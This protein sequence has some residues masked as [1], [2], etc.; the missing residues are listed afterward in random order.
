MERREAER[1]AEEAQRAEEERRA[2]Q[3][4][5]ERAVEVEWQQQAAMDVDGEESPED[6][7]VRE[8][9]AAAE[10]ARLLADARVEEADKR[11]ELA[12][13]KKRKTQPVE[14]ASC[15]RCLNT[16]AACTWVEGK[17]SCVLCTRK[18]VACRMPGDPVPEPRKR[19]ARSGTVTQ[20]SVAGSSNVVTGASSSDVGSAVEEELF[21]QLGAL[22]AGQAKQTKL[23]GSVVGA[24]RGLDDRLTAIADQLEVLVR[25]FGADPD[26]VPE[27]ESLGAEADEE[28]DDE[29]EDEDEDE[30]EDEA[31]GLEAE[32]AEARRR[33]AA[34]KAKG[35]GRARD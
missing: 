1:V 14:G 19:K 25:H 34:R 9:A 33:E 5:R 4:A 12:A 31:A 29:E 17:T 20:A 27:S 2:E 21:Q 22:V 15:V 28:E 6:W 24:V 13:A 3:E 35:K 18:H 7:A 11:I 16:K 30:E 23:L 26:F 8:R 32:A 10:A